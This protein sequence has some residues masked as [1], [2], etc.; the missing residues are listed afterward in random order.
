MNFVAM[1]MITQNCE[2]PLQNV[3]ML[4]VFVSVLC[5]AFCVQ[6]SI[7]FSDN[8][9]FADITNGIRLHYIRAP[10]RVPMGS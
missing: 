9:H 5:S 4:F 3:A 7:E 6:Q 1:A 2:L 8:Q 10:L